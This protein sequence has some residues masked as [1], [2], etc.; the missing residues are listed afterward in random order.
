MRFLYIRSVRKILLQMEPILLE[1][2]TKPNHYCDSMGIYASYP[3]KKFVT[4]SFSFASDSSESFPSAL[5]LP[6]RT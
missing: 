2:M 5:M 3:A 1:E 4:I 6:N